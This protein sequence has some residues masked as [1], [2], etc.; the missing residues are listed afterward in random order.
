MTLMKLFSVT[1]S[2][3]GETIFFYEA[4][5]ATSAID[6]LRQR[7]HGLKIVLYTDSLNTIDIFNS[8]HCSSTFNPLLLFC[9]DTCTNNKFDLQVLHV[10]GVENEVAD[11]ISRRNFG[12]ALKL[13]P[14][15]QLSMFQ[16]PHCAMLGA[17]KK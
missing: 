13:V 8:L 7:E 17:A 4:V 9:V 14:D 5:A 6:N 3:L 11:T 1:P 10:P 15:L 12:K 2:L 16:P